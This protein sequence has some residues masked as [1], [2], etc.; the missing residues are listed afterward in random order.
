MTTRV[1][2][3]PVPGQ[4]FSADVTYARLVVTGGDFAAE[5]GPNSRLEQVIEALQTRGT[6]I[7]FNVVNATTLDLALDYASA[8]GDVNALGKGV[9]GSVETEL[10]AAI[11]GIAGLSAAA[12]TVGRVFATA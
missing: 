8:E 3:G 5:Q 6:V 2:G 7:A 12:L 10:E 1:N 4:W 9:G 11:N